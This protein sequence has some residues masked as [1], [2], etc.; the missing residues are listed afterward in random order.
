MSID[1]EEFDLRPWETELSGGWLDLGSRVVDNEVTVRIHRLLRH[2][3]QKLAESDGGWTVLYRDP[4]DGRLW[5][6]THPHNE[7]HGGGP[8]CLTVIEAARATARFHLS[9]G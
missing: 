2:R 9:A 4:R 8:P 7:I 3:L 6:L 5:E 1:S